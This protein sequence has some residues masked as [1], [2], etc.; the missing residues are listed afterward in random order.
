MHAL[1]FYIDEGFS[2][3]SYSA[4]FFFLHI[5]MRKAASFALFLRAY[6]QLL[7]RTIV[8]SMLSAVQTGK[9]NDSI[10]I[11]RKFSVAIFTN[12]LRFLSEFVFGILWE[13]SRRH[14][15]QFQLG[16]QTRLKLPM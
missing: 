1:K 9:N 6:T 16:G 14:L 8:I 7:H 10:T 4:T 15:V 5:N 2:D 11:F 12:F 13:M 3:V